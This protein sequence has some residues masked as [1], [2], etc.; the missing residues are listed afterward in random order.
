MKS[1]ARLTPVFSRILY[2]QAWE[3]PRVDLEAFGGIGPGD[4]V[5]AI[6]ASGDQTLCFLTHGPRS[7][8]ALDFNLTQ[9]VLLE[10]KIRAVE[11]LTWA[12][13]L[14]FAGVRPCGKRLAYYDRLK[15]DLG[16]QA[17]KF[18]DEHPDVI[19]KGVIHSGRFENFFRIFR[20]AVLPLVASRETVRSLL[21]APTLERQHDIYDKRW[22]TWRWRALFRVFF[23]KRVMAA[24]GRSKAH[25]KYVQRESIGDLLLVRVRRALAEIPVGDNYFLEYILTGEYGDERARLPEWLQ[26]RNQPLIRKYSDRVT[27]VNDEIEQ[28]LPRQ[29]DGAFSKF[30]LSD[31]FEYM[32]DGPYEA[33]LR[34]L[35][36]TARDGGVLSYRNLFA[37]RS[38][39]ESMRD[40]LQPDEDLGRRLNAKDR[41]FFYDRQIVERARKVKAPAP[42][43]G[44]PPGAPAAA[45]STS[46]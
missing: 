42:P 16:E 44:A 14:E 45:S 37:P 36:R 17:R 20:W 32:P 25:F 13:L 41:S 2:A 34:E 15:G 7:I 22:N 6:G 27:I 31:I 24:L 1:E 23:G 26:E 29:K 19:R 43:D 30:Y 40:L 11:R 8:S 33:L 12:E 4:D 39:P 5:F 38:R 10:L 28:F 3:D 18:W 9:C 21:S 35:W 46:R